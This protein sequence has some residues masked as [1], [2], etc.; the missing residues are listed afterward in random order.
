MSLNIGSLEIVSVTYPANPIIAIADLKTQLR[1]AQSVTQYDAI[2]NALQLA[3]WDLIEYKTRRFIF[4]RTIK[5]HLPDVLRTCRFWLPFLPAVG[6]TFVVHTKTGDVTISSANYIQIAETVTV[7]PSNFIYPLGI[8][9][10]LPFQGYFQYSTGY[11]DTSGNTAAIPPGLIQLVTQLVSLNHYAGSGMSLS[12][13]ITELPNN[14]DAMLDAYV[15][16]RPET[17]LMSVRWP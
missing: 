3:A 6:L 5:V 15:D 17:L 7:Q 4:N 12:P 14:F 2:L 8:N 9:Y 10:D 1:I 11:I 16:K 13:G